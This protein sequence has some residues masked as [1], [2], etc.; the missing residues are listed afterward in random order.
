MPRREPPPFQ[1]LKSDNCA[2]AC[3]RSVLAL[4]GIAVDEEMLEPLAHKDVWGVEIEH[5]A[6]AARHFGLRV[7]ILRLDLPAI[8]D[9]LARGVFPIVY[10]NRVHFDR[11]FP[12][13]RRVALRTF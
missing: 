9:Y 4:H 10:L 3:L 1:Q 5:L 6:G 7:D 12:V 13:P 2:L 11:R 8:A